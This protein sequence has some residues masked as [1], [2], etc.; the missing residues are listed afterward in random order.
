MNLGLN[1]VDLVILGLLILFAVESFGRSL[2][3]ELI[4]FASFL[5]AFILSFRYY[6]IPAKFFE[7]QFHIPHGLSL[8]LG[9]MFVWFISEAVFYLLVRFVLP[10]IPRVKF[11]GSNFLSII[12]GF[13]RCLIFISIALVIIATFPIQPV[14]KKSVLDSKIGSEILKYAYGLER[15]VKQ[16]FGGVANDSF[17]FLTIKPKTDEKVN[18]GFQTDKISPDQISENLMLDLVNKERTSRGLRVL[19]FDPK[20]QIVARGHSEDMFKRGYFSH[21]SLEGK[22]VADRALSREVAFWVIGENL[23]YAPS[24]ELAHKGLMNSEGHRANILSPDFNRI[25]IGSLDG[26]IYG[27]MFTQVFTD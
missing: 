26:G 1:W 9:F 22:T 23:A 16:V 11:F 19:A 14:V 13:L 12:P 3:F 4:D 20:L 21:Y 25:G 24:I 5:L 18:L 7:A 8:V 2:V 15:P 17:T 6:N 27:K 10:K